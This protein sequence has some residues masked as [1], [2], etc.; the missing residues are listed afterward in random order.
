MIII[1]CLRID[2]WQTNKFLLLC[3][4][5][6]S[7]MKGILSNTGGPPPFK[8]PSRSVSKCL[9]RIRG[10]DGIKMYGPKVGNSKKK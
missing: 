6:A 1:Q 5:S 8:M 9:S 4:M 7:K 3:L 10:M 2:A